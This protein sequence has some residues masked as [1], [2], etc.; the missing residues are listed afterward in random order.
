MWP[1]LPSGHIL[2][3]PP[4]TLGTAMNPAGVFSRVVQPPVR[5]WGTYIKHLE[6]SPRATKSATSVAAA[7]LGDALAQNISNIDK[8]QWE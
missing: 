1:T 4:C 2:V 7:I 6:K 3:P 5:L 8:P